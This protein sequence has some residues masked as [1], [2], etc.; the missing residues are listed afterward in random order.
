[1]SKRIL[2]TLFVLAST[3][4]F[5]ACDMT[6]GTQMDPAIRADERMEQIVSTIKDKDSAALKALF[7]EKALTEVSD[8][9]SEIVD[10]FGIIQGDIESWERHGYSGK[11]LNEYGKQTS[12]KL[13]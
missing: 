4:L 12:V 11:G 9:D 13:S 2:L 1:M 6:G 10:L 5:N 3:L 8:I 7:S